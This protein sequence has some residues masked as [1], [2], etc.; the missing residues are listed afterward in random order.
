LQDILKVKRHTS[1]WCHLA[2]GAICNKPGYVTKVMQG[3]GQ[4]INVMLNWGHENSDII[5]I[6][7]GKNQWNS[8]PKLLYASLVDGF[9]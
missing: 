1:N 9:A 7:R 5:G 2:L 4:E 6:E 3:G 8:S